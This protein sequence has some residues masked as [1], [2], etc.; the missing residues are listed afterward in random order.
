MFQT[1]KVGKDLMPNNKTSPRGE[2]TKGFYKDCWIKV[3]INF[4]EE[5]FTRDTGKFLASGSTQ[6]IVE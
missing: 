4:S 3:G 2:I 6:I 5:S 1:I